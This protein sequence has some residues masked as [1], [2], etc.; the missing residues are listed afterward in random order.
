MGVCGR[1]GFKKSISHSNCMMETEVPNFVS[2]MSRTIECNHCCEL[3]VN[4][5][6]LSAHEKCVQMLRQ[7]KLYLS[8]SKS[9]P[10]LCPLF[11]KFCKVQPRYSYR[12]YS[13]K[14]ECTSLSH[15]Y[16]MYRKRAAVFLYFIK[17]RSVSFLNS[18]KN[19]PQKACLL[20]VQTKVQIVRGKY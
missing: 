11:L 1:F 8:F 10:R 13:Y 14:I 3:F 6:G 19:I 7:T 5:Q 12:M 18:F 20:G 16:V 15:H 17:T 4:Q 2:T 9:Q